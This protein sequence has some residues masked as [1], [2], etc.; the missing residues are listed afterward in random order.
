MR[1]IL[2]MG[3]VLIIGNVLMMDVLIMGNEL[4]MGVLIMSRDSN[5]NNK[6]SQFLL[7][8]NFH[9]QPNWE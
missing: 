4:I 9:H 5:N 3:N 2:I 6:N 1:N 8:R 7:F